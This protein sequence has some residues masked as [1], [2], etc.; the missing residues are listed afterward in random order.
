[1]LTPEQRAK[2][3]AYS[4]ATYLLYFL[5]FGF[6]VV[7]Y[8]LV[9]RARLVVQLRDFAR[10][11]SRRLWVEVLIVV[12]LFVVLASLLEF[13][14]EYSSGFVLERQFGLSVQSFAGWF[15]DWLKWLAVT[16][17]LALPLAWVFYAI[18]RR[19]P[20]RW[21]VFFWLMSLPMTLAFLLAEP[22]VVEP[23]FFGFTPL[24]E[25]HP[26]LATRIERMLRHAN[27]A[28]PRERIFKMDASSKVRT[29]NAYVAGLGPTK[30]VVVW[31]NT[32]AKLNEEEILLVVGHETGH[33]VLDHIPKEFVLIEL[34][35][36]ACFYAGFVAFEKI[37]RRWG[38]PGG[39]ESLGDLASLP[40]VVLVLSVLTFLSSPLVN[41]VSRHYEHQAD[42]F[43]LEVAYGVVPDPNDAETRSL[44]VL[45]EEDLADPAPPAFIK[46]W[47]YSHPPLDERIRFAASYRP[48][49]QGKPLQLVHTA[50]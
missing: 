12:P 19:S 45:G 47:L 46:F 38:A 11:R 50:P 39:V 8:L 18:V 7:I 22:Y 4:R 20:R 36:L 21:W 3:I 15:G 9:W 43:G 5:G 17:A 35:V 6:S 28:I 10:Q 37:F 16:T 24:E 49:T 32:L 29:V 34:V 48:W 14:I 1:M 27:L 23:L 31:D 13:P 25:T 30:R 26:G 33:Y 42:Q 44:Q 40:V 2:A 41:A